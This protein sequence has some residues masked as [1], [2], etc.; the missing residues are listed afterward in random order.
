[1]TLATGC[2]A[3][4][5][6]RFSG[7]RPFEAARF[8]CRSERTVKGAVEITTFQLNGVG[9]QA[10]IAANAGVDAWLQRQ[11]GFRS[12]HI[13][14]RDDGSVV[15]VLMWDSA[16]QSTEAAHRLMSELVQSPVH[17]MIDQRTLS[18]SVVPVRH[19]APA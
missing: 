7:C 6:S 13:A 15:D 14:Q 11:P 10:F 1:M 17:A 12:R 18:W 4:G 16:A 5:A 2:A 19:R 9:L 3:H 8:E